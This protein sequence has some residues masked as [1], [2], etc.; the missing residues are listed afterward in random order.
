MKSNA[1]LRSGLLLA[2]IV[3]L[4]LPMSAE[5]AVEAKD[6]T[7]GST[8]ESVYTI[9]KP[10][11]PYEFLVTNPTFNPAYL[12]IPSMDVDMLIPAH[13]E[14]AITIDMSSAGAGDRI[15]YQVKD[16][17]DEKVVVNGFFTTI[18]PD[19]PKVAE[20]DAN[21]FA[22]FLTNTQQTLD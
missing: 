14:R 5:A 11:Q 7:I 17:T 8:Y 18:D 3:A 4:S 20:V 22:A 6:L 13:S 16:E 21:R 2:G 19:A 12:V 9:V 1:L 15:D 10:D